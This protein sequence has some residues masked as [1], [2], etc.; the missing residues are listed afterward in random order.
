M[1]IKKDGEMQTLNT[2]R[3]MIIRMDIAPGERL[4]ERWLETILNVSRTPIREALVRL[5]NEGLVEREGKK[6]ICSPIDYNEIEEIC[7][8]REAIEAG[9]VSY[10]MRNNE[11]T[12]CLS[13]ML[14]DIRKVK[15]DGY[16]FH[17]ELA[18]VSGNRF[19]VG[20][21]DEVLNKLSRLRYFSKGGGFYGDEEHE[22]IL[23]TMCS[24]DV[25]K[26]VHLMRE[27]ISKNSR[28]LINAMRNAHLSIK[29]IRR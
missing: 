29:S 25:T 15:P 1:I 11:S 10:I 13:V 8:Y 27:H 14:S 24:G 2:L 18:K 6:W 19:F 26:A 7:I 9:V 23:R 3:E 22:I 4:T 5:Q 28:Q 16:N 12:E 17:V 20:T 21:I